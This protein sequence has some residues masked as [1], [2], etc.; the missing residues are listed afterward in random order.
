MIA[1]RRQ[2]GYLLVTVVVTLFLLATLAV[3]LAQTSAISANT[4]SAELETVRA[5]YVTQ[6]GMQHA[7]WRVA[8]NACMGDV[9]IPTTSLGPDSYA[10]ATTGAAAGTAF[11]RDAD[12]DAWIRS[13][14]PDKNNNSTHNH[15]RFEAG[16]V[17]VVLTRFDLSGIAANAQINSAVAWFHL[18]AGKD[19]PEGSITVHEITTPWD[20]STVTWDSFGDAYQPGPIGM[21]PAQDAGDV[22][23]SFNLTGLVQAWVNGQPNNGIL[24]NSEAEGLHTEYTAREDGTN[25]PR[26]EVV[27]GSGPASPV[28]VQVT[29]TLENGVSRTI[30]RVDVPVY[31]AAWPSM[32]VLQPGPEGKDS[33]IQ[34]PH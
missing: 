17:E 23:V 16:K 13:D 8:N 28:Q 2:R 30:E 12:Q 34:G 27:V 22:W 29:G 18:K 7:L 5:D 10:A 24:F 31:N 21:I 6:A 19:H 26:L 15:V 3:L 32:I 1:Y 11:V 25:P 4:A 33:F 20:E 9:T 14:D